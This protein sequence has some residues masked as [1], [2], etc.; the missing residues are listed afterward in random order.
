MVIEVG[1]EVFLKNTCL[2][3]GLYGAYS[4]STVSLFMTWEMSIVNLCLVNVIWVF[5]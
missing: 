2:G 1:K 4:S 3:L 5:E